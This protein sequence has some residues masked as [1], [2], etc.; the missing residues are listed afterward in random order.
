MMNVA[1]RVRKEVVQRRL[2]Q[3]PFWAAARTRIVLDRLAPGTTVVVVNWNSASFLRVCLRAIRSHSPGDIRVLVVDN[4]S[5]DDSMKLLRGTPDVQRLRLPRNVGHESAL[6]IGFLSAR[7]DNVIAL[8]VD[9]FPITSH[10]LDVLVG[11][12]GQGY[13]VAGAHVH[14]GFVHP[15][16]LAMRLRNFVVRRHT[17]IARRS[18]R[19]AESADDVNAPGWDTGWKISLREPC[20]YLIDRTTVRGPGDIGSVFGD[21]VYHNFYSTRLNNPTYQVLSDRELALGIN[22]DDAM[23]AWEEAVRKYVR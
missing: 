15:C 10:W 11:A 1:S 8:D 16:C 13:A 14:G 12:L 23:N 20:R 2:I 4:N 9:A 3:A 17:F 6:D 18:E 19:W 21:L 22:R 7:T 5:T